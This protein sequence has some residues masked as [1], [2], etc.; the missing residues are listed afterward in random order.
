MFIKDLI[1]SPRK[2]NRI[3]LASEDINMLTFLDTT[4]YRTPRIVA[5]ASLFHK[6]NYLQ[7]NCT[8]KHIKIYQT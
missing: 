5:L 3:P 7:A 4:E 2:V 8:E 1:Q 6:V